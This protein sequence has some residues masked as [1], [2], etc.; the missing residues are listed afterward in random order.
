MKNDIHIFDEEVEHEL[1]LCKEEED[2]VRKLED[3][4]KNALSNLEKNN[5]KRRN[6]I[7]NARL[8]KMKEIKNEI[9]KCH[10]IIDNL[11]NSEQKYYEAYCEKK[12]KHNYI[13]RERIFGLI[14]N[15]D[16]YKCQ[17]C[18]KEK[19][20]TY[21]GVPEDI[22]SAELKKREIGSDFKKDEYFPG[23]GLVDRTVIISGGKELFNVRKPEEKVIYS[24]ERIKPD[25]FYDVIS[26]TEDEKN[27]EDIKGEIDKIKDFE[28]YLKSLEVSLC[29]MF[30]HDIN[31]DDINIDD[32]KND[33]DNYDYYYSSLCIC[34][35]YKIYMG[36]YIKS[37][38]NAKYKGI[39]PGSE[40]FISKN[41]YEHMMSSTFEVKIDMPT[42]DGYQKQLKKL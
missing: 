10:T 13:L 1:M 7:N 42:F 36:E 8:K 17:I 20:N 3:S 9:K 31:I 35:G 40:H 2:E 6:L 15:A 37:L 4:Y 34:C 16:I 25:D 27:L 41:S 33:G 38:E 29:K 21:S 39:I 5:K 28:C 14:D 30:G 19:K 11:E 32:I 18:G 12:G 24:Y 26:L 22:L 23:Y